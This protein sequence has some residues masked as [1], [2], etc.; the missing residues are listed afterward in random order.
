MRC[1]ATAAT[2]RHGGRRSPSAGGA[3]SRSD[4]SKAESA[5]GRSAEVPTLRLHES[6]EHSMILRTPT[7]AAAAVFT[8]RRGFLPAELRSSSLCFRP[9]GRHGDLVP[10]AFDGNGER[11]GGD[12]RG[13]DFC[14]PGHGG[15]HLR[16]EDDERSPNPIN[17]TLKRCGRDRPVKALDVDIP[18]ALEIHEVHQVREAGELKRQH[19]AGLDVPGVIG[20]GGSLRLVGDDQQLAPS[21]RQF[22]GRS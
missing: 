20:R 3:G 5:L 1:C 18:M 15:A 10:L 12:F 19:L 8:Y 16:H 14:A 2:A 22:A 9:G 7:T 6:E 21:Q 13:R 17:D 11:V 4:V